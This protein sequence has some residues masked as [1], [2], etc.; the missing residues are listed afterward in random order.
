MCIDCSIGPGKKLHGLTNQRRTKIVAIFLCSRLDLWV[1]DATILVY[2]AESSICRH[3][4][5]IPRR[6]NSTRLSPLRTPIDCSFEHVPHEHT[7]TKRRVGC[8]LH[9]NKSWSK[10]RNASIEFIRTSLNACLYVHVLHNDPFILNSFTYHTHRVSKTVFQFRHLTGWMKQ[11][12]FILHTN[13]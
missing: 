11:R 12:A 9:K 10:K 6:V 4:F 1:H 13:L 7:S 2:F 5:Q 8:S 3:L